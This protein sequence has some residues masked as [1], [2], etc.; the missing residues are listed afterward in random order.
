MLARYSKPDA[1]RD[2]ALADTGKG[3]APPDGP[4]NSPLLFYGESLGYY[5]AIDGRPFVG[6]AGS[7]FARVL[8]RA[9][10]D[11]ENVRVHNIV[12]CQPPGDWLDGAPWEHTAINH[13]QTHVQGNLD[14]W[15]RATAH[16]R[17]RVVVT[18]GGLPLRTLLQLP[19]SAGVRVQDFHGTVHRDPTDRFWVVPTYH[20][21]H[22]QRGALNLLDV[23]R[24]DLGVAS[25]VLT[26]GHTPTPV[27]LVCDPEVAWFTRWVDDF[28]AA[29]AQDPDGV[30]LPLDIETPDKAGG[31]DEGELS[32]EDQSTQILRVNVGCRTDEG[33]TVPYVG[34][35]IAQIQ[36]LLASECIKLLWN[37]NYDLT[38]LKYNG[39]AINGDCWDLMWAAKHLQSDL[40]LGLG[41]WAPFYSDFGAWKHWSKIPGREKE[42][43]AVDG[44]QTLRIGHGIVKDLVEQNLWDGFYRHNHELETYVLRPAHE[45]GVG[46]D[47]A[48]L[49]A[50]HTKLNGIAGEKLE[51]LKGY[52]PAGQLRPKQGYTKRPEGETCDACHGTGNYNMQDGACPACAGRGILPPVP[53]ASVIGKTKNAGESD[54][55]LDY[56]KSGVKLIEQAVRTTV[57]SCGTCGK[58]GVLKSHRCQIPK[59]LSKEERTRLKLAYA[60]GPSLTEVWVDQPRWFW[61]LPFNPDAPRQLLR[62]IED[63]GEKA[64]RNKQTKN[65]AADKATLVRLAKKTGDPIYQDVLDYKAVKKVDSTY[66]VGCKRRIWADGRLHPFYT[67]RPS[68]FRLSYVNPNITNVV[69]DKGGKDSLAAGFRECI[70]AAQE[71]PE[72]APEAA[73]QEEI[74][75]RGR[76][77]MV[78]YGRA[79]ALLGCRLLEV[80]YSGI[81]AV[82]TGWYIGD[83]DTIRLAT[84]GIHAYL[85]SHLIGD[86]ASLAWS[87]ADLSAFFSQIKKKQPQAYD[88]A[89]RCVHG[90]NYGLT[91]FGMAENFPDLFQTPKEAQRVQELYYALVPKLPGWHRA[92]RDAAHTNGRLGGPQTLDY[93]QLTSTWLYHPFGYRHWFWGVIGYKPIT[94]TQVQRM[95]AAGKKTYTVINGR[96]FKILYGEDSK[97]V[98]AFFP[99]STAAGVLKEAM[100]RLFHP[101]APSFIGDQFYGRTPLRAPIHDSLLLEIPARRFDY[102]ASV[103]LGE[104]QR[105]ILQQPLPPE[106]GR[107]SHLRVGVAAKTGLDWMHMEDLDVAGMASE[108]ANEPMYLG[109][110]EDDI[111]E[112]GALERVVEEAGLGDGAGA[113]QVAV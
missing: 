68:T 93:G 7:M 110:T 11:R 54:A 84:L 23:V 103:V 73:K 57:L 14:S 48:R 35:Y 88:K 83:P 81:E 5:E 8:K 19:R 16:F 58:E 113:V 99:Q 85:T 71:V 76:Q 64:G 101:D 21:S 1:C 63:K 69:A 53:P 18:M 56:M 105:P 78:A 2:C 59:G 29:L 80:D 70:V 40:P 67:F 55:K 13:C 94:T 61:Q 46:I 96:P 106:W 25:R 102:V 20:P 49:D 43:A 86:P 60:A 44:V 50:F 92:L 108:V 74:A 111:E 107:G 10:L 45:V 100:L 91:T 97:R 95:R 87:D 42:Y 9:G 65:P 4:A 82:E 31:R 75:E 47:V 34:P 28:L 72:W 33:I 79:P 24:F 6:P 27:S 3:F 12:N 112:F 37:K 38:R 15:A 26:Q 104:M 30:W 32:S 39:H 17:E 98:I 22:L 52:A 109:E 62:Y 89:K 36:R 66:V 51:K 41:F 77:A 90:N